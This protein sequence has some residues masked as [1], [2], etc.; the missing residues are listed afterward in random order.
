MHPHLAEIMP[1][2]G[3]H[4]RAGSRL[5]RLSGS[6]QDILHDGR[7]TDG[8]R[9]IARQ[10]RRA[11]QLAPVQVAFAVQTGGDPWPLQRIRL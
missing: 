11:G 2:A 6:A 8:L 10:A 1:E 7:Q 9:L 3:F 5:Q 4:K